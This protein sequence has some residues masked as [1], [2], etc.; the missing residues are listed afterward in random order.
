MSTQN[1]VRFGF[2]R[3]SFSG[4]SATSVS[5]ISEIVDVDCASS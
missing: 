5:S 3:S 1:Q 4:M 2:K